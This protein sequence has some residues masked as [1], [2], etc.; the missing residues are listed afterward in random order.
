MREADRGPPSVRLAEDTGWIEFTRSIGQRLLKQ[1]IASGLTQQQ[2]AEM[3][4]IQPES[5]SRIE[6][7]VIVPTLLRLRQ[8]SRVYRCSLVALL[9]T[10]SVQ[11]SDLAIR[12]TEDLDGLDE[13]DRRFVA[14]QVRALAHHLRGAASAQLERRRPARTRSRVERPTARQR[15][16]NPGKR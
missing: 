4:G 12:M 14:T 7:G 15:S 3:I 2:A 13:S 16:A 8:F 6:T 11:P 1:R 10:A 5:V 9:E